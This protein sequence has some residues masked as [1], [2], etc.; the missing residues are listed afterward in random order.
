MTQVRDARDG[1]GLTLPPARRVLLE[2]LG[3]ASP[4]VSPNVAAA[5]MAAASSP[6]YQVRAGMK[7][8]AGGRVDVCVGRGPCF[9]TCC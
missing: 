3:G 2:P 5:A 8:G 7:H 1:A 4:A 9:M 6:F